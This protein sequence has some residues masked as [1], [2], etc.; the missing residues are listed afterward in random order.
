LGLN[1]EKL[2]V[3]R[4]DDQTIPDQENWPL[5]N[6]NYFLQ[7]QWEAKW[8][9]CLWEGLWEGLPTAGLLGCRKQ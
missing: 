7:V 9:N 4:K 6:Y 2:F 5:V 1:K 3:L 8:N